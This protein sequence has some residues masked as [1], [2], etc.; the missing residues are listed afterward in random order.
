MS[1]D[2]SAKTRATVASP[3]GSKA[4]C[5]DAQNRSGSGEVPFVASLSVI[6]DRPVSGW[7]QRRE[8]PGCHMK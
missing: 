1:L 2:V 5:R 4:P 6:K 3:L 8:H 7:V